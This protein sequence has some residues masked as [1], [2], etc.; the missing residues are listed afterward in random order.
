[1]DTLVDNGTAVGAVGVH[2]KHIRVN[3][4]RALLHGNLLVL[5]YMGV[6]AGHDAVRKEHLPKQGVV[7]GQMLLPDSEAHAL[8]QNFHINGS[9]RGEGLW[10]ILLKE[11][12]GNCVQLVFVDD[13]HQ[14]I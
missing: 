2:E 8:C 4:D 12:C 14:I 1:M 13:G 9:G 5:P 11:V 10:I 6:I 7:L 3:E